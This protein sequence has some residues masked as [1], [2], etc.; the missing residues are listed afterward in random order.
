M[1]Y[2]LWEEENNYYF[3]ASSEWSEG[4]NFQEKVESATYVAEITAEMYA[5]LSAGLR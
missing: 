5:L 3:A 4:F 2:I 1:E